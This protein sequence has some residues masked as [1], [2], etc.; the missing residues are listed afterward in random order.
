MTTFS[1]ITPAVYLIAIG[2]VGGAVAI[3]WFLVN[4]SRWRGSV[5]TD[6]TNFT[7]F[8]EEIRERIEQIQQQIGQIFNHLAANSL[9]TSGSPLTLTDLGRKI[10]ARLDAKAW[11]KK[12]AAQVDTT[13]MNAYR[14]QEFC[15]AYVKDEDRQPFSDDERE[16]IQD[17]AFEHGQKTKQIVDVFAIEL[18]DKL[19]AKAGLDTP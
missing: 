13:G 3:V 2:V 9:I 15:F 1:W 16:A 5:D 14:I 18:R 12:H 8:V 6:R 10:S 7:K 11:A 4:H 19:L 17:A